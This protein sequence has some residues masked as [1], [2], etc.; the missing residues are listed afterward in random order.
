[1][2]DILSNCLEIGSVDAMFWG[3]GYRFGIKPALYPFKNNAFKNRIMD[4]L[5][6]GRIF[7]KDG[8][9]AHTVEGLK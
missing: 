9:L 7:G 2:L 6:A 1:M 3:G 8:A 5:Y 4:D